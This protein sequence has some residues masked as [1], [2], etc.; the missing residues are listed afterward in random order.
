VSSPRRPREAGHDKI[1]GSSSC[2][3]APSARVGRRS[4]R[5]RRVPSRTGAPELQRCAPCQTDPLRW[6]EERS[7]SVCQLY[8]GSDR[9]DSNSLQRRRS[10]GRS[11]DSA[12]TPSAPPAAESSAA[13]RCLQS[14]LIRG[15]GAGCS[16]APCRRRGPW[17]KPGHCGGR[18]NSP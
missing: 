9:P 5:S 11:S 16:C 18:R 4:T 1:V 14:L 17:A 7:V 15:G 3:E 8:D 12:T 13:P 6:S 10:R 2:S